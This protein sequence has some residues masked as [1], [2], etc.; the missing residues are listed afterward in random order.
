MLHGPV[1]TRKG[2]YL[3]YSESALILD[4]TEPLELSYPHVHLETR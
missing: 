3:F 1:E 4:V 2:G